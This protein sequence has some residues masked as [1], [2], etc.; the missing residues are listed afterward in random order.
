[1]VA[2]WIII[3]LLKP[4]SFL[5]TSVLKIKCMMHHHFFTE[6]KP[7]LSSPICL[8]TTG[9]KSLFSLRVQIWWWCSN[10]LS[11][12]LAL[13][14]GFTFVRQ[15]RKINGTTV[16]P[17]PQSLTFTFLL[18]FARSWELVFPYKTPRFLNTVNRFSWGN[19]VHTRCVVFSE[20]W[21]VKRL[22]I[23]RSSPSARWILMKEKSVTF[24]S[25]WG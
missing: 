5:W 1:M 10:T 7:K 4:L 25:Q 6:M 8:H 12:M 18:V 3:E 9:S 11:R 19:I 17:V 22:V 14:Q 23:A 2:V 16:N 21:P 24:A 15:S 20:R 13:T